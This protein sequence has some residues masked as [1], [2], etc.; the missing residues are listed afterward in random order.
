MLLAAEH[1]QKLGSKQHEEAWEDVV[2]LPQAGFDNCCFQLSIQ[3]PQAPSQVRVADLLSNA[4]PIVTGEEQ[5]S[6]A[7]SVFLNS[8]HTAGHRNVGNLEASVKIHFISSGRWL[9]FESY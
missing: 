3:M 9:W 4:L 7:V 2:W 5:A 1:I 8:F 6:R